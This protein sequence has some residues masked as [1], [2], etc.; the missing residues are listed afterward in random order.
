MRK[1]FWYADR[2]A[3]RVHH[4][5]GI[6]HFQEELSLHIFQYSSLQQTVAM[7]GPPLPE[8]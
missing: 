7:T 6:A 2:V 8:Q 1:A 3:L 5:R 4:L